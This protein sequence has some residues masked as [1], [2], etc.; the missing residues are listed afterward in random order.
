MPAFKTVISLVTALSLFISPLAP[1]L[2][3]VAQESPPKTTQYPPTLT[4]WDPGSLEILSADNVVVSIDL[5]ADLSPR[6]TATLVDPDV[7]GEFATTL[8][9]LDG[10]ES[11]MV[12]GVVYPDETILIQTTRAEALSAGF[13]ASSAGGYQSARSAWSDFWSGYWYYL[14]HPSA[15]D[16]DLET[17]FYVAVGTAAVAGTAAGGLYIV[18]INPVIWGGGAATS[19]SLTGGTVVNANKL[20]HIFGKAAHKLGGLLQSFGGNQTAAFNAVQN[21]TVAALANAGVTSGTFQITV[22]VAGMKITV[23]G[24]I[25]NG[26]V[27]IA[28]FFM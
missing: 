12:W 26:I 24:I 28:T 7:P 5:A 19:G 14:T 8:V 4:A 27:Y 2:R 11:V 1:Q 3:C 21:A 10:F 25:Q 9:S 13:S 22:T 23:R 18:G 16:N 20:W 15:M 6:V 17:G